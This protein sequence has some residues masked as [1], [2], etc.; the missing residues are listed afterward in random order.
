M[1]EPLWSEAELVRAFGA[2][3]S[4]PLRAPVEGVSIDTRMLAPGDVFFAIK[5]ETGDGHDHVARAFAA[6][7]GACVVERARSSDGA[8]LGPVFAVEDT[9]R[10][11]ERLGVAARARTG[12]RIVAVTG[13]VG[14]TSAKE[15]LRVALG[16]NGP[17]HASAASYNNHWG[18]PLTLGRMPAA[19]AYG[20]FE[21]GMNHPGEISPL[22]AMVRPH[23]ALVTTI[24]PVHIEYLGSIEAIA[25][26][27]A[28]IFTG[29]EPG[30][31]IVLNREAPQFSLLEKRAIIARRKVATFGANARADGQLLHFEPEGEGVRVRASINGR[32]ISFSLGAPGLHMAQNAVGVLLAVDALGADVAQATAA[33]AEFSAPK[34]RGS[35][36]TLHAAGGAFTLIDESY[37]ANPASM[38]AALSLLGAAR[39]GSGGRRI[40]VLG[41][42]L[43][44]GPEGPQAHIDLASD[45][46][47]N[48]VDLLFCVGPLMR[49][50]FEASPQAIRGFW[51]ERSADIK[52]SL[53]EAARGG[54]VVMVKGSNGSAMGPIVAA[55]RSHFS[56]AQSGGQG[57]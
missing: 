43:E 26:A 5:S 34:G 52:E 51:A 31:T 8:A 10:A 22:V 57:T 55:L 20:V 37:N 2:P 32:E 56:S 49:G 18:V 27:K 50:L 19:F 16:R 23:V 24:A 25:E 42:M 33:L 13:S 30:G 40:A 44:L 39:P 29:V 12:A 28:E 4:A 14:K 11:M 53:F 7:A 47:R 6:G 36:I 35:R 17:T 21:I 45:L 54:D 3:A 15:M 9:L 1:T 46:A 41:D 38:R 48:N